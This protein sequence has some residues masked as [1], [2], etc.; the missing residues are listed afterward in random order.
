MPKIKVTKN[1]NS[2]E[3][4]MLNEVLDVWVELGN[5]EKVVHLLNALSYMEK[6]NVKT[7]DEAIAYALGYHPMIE[8][9]YWKKY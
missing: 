6:H 2:N 9:D 1:S 7:R 4:K 8:Q 3:P 5:K